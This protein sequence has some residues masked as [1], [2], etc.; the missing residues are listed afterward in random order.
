MTIE[1]IFVTLKVVRLYDV[2]VRNSHTSQGV[3]DFGSCRVCSLSRIVLKC[4]GVSLLSSPNVIFFPYQF[5]FQIPAVIICVT[6]P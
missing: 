6:K 1:Y 3:G 4:G 5:C 2:I